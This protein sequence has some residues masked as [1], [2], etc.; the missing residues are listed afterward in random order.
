MVPSGLRWSPAEEGAEATER[1]RCLWLRRQQRANREHAPLLIEPE[2]A[3]PCLCAP[4]EPDIDTRLRLQD[5]CHRSARLTEQP[6]DL[7]QRHSWSEA[8][9]VRP[10]HAWQRL[11]Q[12]LRHSQRQRHHRQSDADPRHLPRPA[13]H[14]LC[15]PAV[16]AADG[17]SEK[18]AVPALPVAQSA[19]QTTA[20]KII[21]PRWRWG[22]KAVV[23]CFH[24]WSDP[25]HEDGDRVTQG[26]QAALLRLTRQS[27]AT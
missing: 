20:A 1:G 12:P 23:R 22:S 26:A 14:G 27:A 5:A 10:R 16:T 4:D 25:V 21:R 11:Q 6:F 7:C 9:D 15:P 18:T 19:E 2:E 13:F 3:I 17:A 8:L 24:T